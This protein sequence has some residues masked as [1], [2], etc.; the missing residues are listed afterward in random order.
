METQFYS[1]VCCQVREKR[2]T[3][4]GLP[5]MEGFLHMVIDISMAGILHIVID[6]SMAGILHIVIDNYRIWL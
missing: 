2:T 5:F 1:G 4:I 6:I 3:Q